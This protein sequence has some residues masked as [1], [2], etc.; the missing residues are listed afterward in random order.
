MSTLNPILYLVTA[1]TEG[2]TRAPAGAPLDPATRRGSKI[3]DGVAKCQVSIITVVRA[4]A[5]DDKEESR[6]S[7]EGK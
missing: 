4:E 5:H 6:K 7:R 3:R 1:Y 2:T